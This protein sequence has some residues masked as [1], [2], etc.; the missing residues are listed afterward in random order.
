MEAHVEHSAAFPEWESFEQVIPPAVSWQRAGQGLAN[1]ANSDQFMTISGWDVRKYV[2]WP[3]QKNP[4]ARARWMYG[5]ENNEQRINQLRATEPYGFDL[6]GDPWY[7]AVLYPAPPDPI[8]G[9]ADLV[10]AVNWTGHLGCIWPSDG[11]LMLPLVQALKRRGCYFV[12]PVI[13]GR[14]DVGR[15]QLFNLLPFAREIRALLGQLG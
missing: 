12:V 6:E 10:G 1:A 11:E 15:D 4:P 7:P 2:P 8:Y 3:S 13:F 9:L 14:D 5:W